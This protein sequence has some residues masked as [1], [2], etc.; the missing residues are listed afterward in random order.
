MRLKNCKK[1]KASLRYWY[2]RMY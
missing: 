2:S 1:L